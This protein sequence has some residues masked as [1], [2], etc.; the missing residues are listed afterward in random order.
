MKRRDY[1]DEEEDV[2]VGEAVTTK[3]VMITLDLN[4]MLIRSLLLDNF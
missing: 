2:V 4:S 3:R 1:G